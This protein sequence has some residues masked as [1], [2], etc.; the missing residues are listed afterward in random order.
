M[1][2]DQSRSTK[3]SK[4][5]YAKNAQVGDQV[6]I[7]GSLV[8][9]E[10]QLKRWY[11]SRA[12][13]VF[14]NGWMLERLEQPIKNRLVVCYES[15][16]LLPDGTYKEVVNRATNH[17]PGHWK[18]PNPPPRVS[19]HG[20]SPP[21]EVNTNQD[22]QVSTL[23]N[24]VNLLEMESV[25]GDDGEVP[26]L[27]PDELTFGD[28]PHQSTPDVSL[29]AYD[30]YTIEESNGDDVNGP[31]PAINWRFTGDDG[32]YLEA[33]D[34]LSGT[35]R[36][37]LEYFMNTM[38]P[39]TL[40][41]MLVKT[42]DLLIARESNPMTMA[43]LLRFIGVCLLITRFEFGKRRELWA[44]STGCLYI[45]S[46]GLQQTGMSRDRFEE[47]LAH[48]VFSCQ[49]PVRPTD[50]SSQDYRWQLVD[51]FVNDFNRHRLAR[52]KPSHKVC[53]ESVWINLTLCQ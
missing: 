18:D 25:D 53:S 20:A 46:P 26:T 33:N 35:K 30:W 19:I 8:T 48:V 13:S 9:S 24:S 51:D 15:S 47:I 39:P 17:L 44:L 14:I 16:F 6:H 27:E 11:G 50:M 38:P 7:K 10:S 4:V 42:N 40:R 36:G 37:V 21:N 32:D 12:K 41:R 1:S 45:P 31:V 49:D 34:D 28:I 43:E 23:D 3:A 5:K 52:F 22:D 2:T 29:G